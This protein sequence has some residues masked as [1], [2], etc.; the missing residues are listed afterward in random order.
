MYILLVMIYVLLKGVL[1][2]T[3]LSLVFIELSYSV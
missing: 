2:R 1:K 3:V